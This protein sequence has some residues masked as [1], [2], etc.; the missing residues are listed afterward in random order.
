[1]AMATHQIDLMKLWTQSTQEAERKL[2]KLLLTGLDRRI[3]RS[4]GLTKR[5]K[6]GAAIDG[7]IVRWMEE[8][9][10]PQAVTGFWSATSTDGFTV[11]GNLF[12][13]AAT[14][15]NMVKVIRAG[16]ILERSSDGLQVKVSAVHASA[17]T[18]TAAMYGNSGSASGFDSG[19]VTWELMGEPWS[20]YSEADD[21]RALDRTFREVG[22][23][24]HAE[25]FEIPKTRENTKYEIVGD[26]VSHQIDALLEKMQRSL[27]KAIL[28]MRPYYS[29]GYKFANQTETSTMCGVFTWPEIVQAECANTNV[30]V[31][32]ATAE[33]SKEYM[34]NLALYLWLD[35]HANYQNGDWIFCCHPLLARYIHDLDISYRRKTADDKSLGFEIDVFESKIGK[36]FPIVIDEYMRKDVLGLINCDKISWG[37]YKNDTLDRKEI[38]TK[39]RF[40]QWLLSFQTYGTVVRDPRAS[41][42]MIYGLATT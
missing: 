19:A 25:T 27:E 32:A 35:E 38:A 29:G 10:Y 22:T 26:E 9:G 21:T 41:I 20:D 16:T 30:Y 23:Q 24:I 42:G 31:N 2:A 39:G 33:I 40:R 14:H 8:E 37:Y 34:D 13:A 11:S 12:G 6:K 3:A 36:T 1:M 28:R 15:A 17:L 5:F 7:P 18:C 4:S